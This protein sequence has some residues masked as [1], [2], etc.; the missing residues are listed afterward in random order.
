MV[1]M[2]TASRVYEK[3]NELLGRRGT[4]IV[5]PPFYAMR[6]FPGPPKFFLRLLVVIITQKDW[7]ESLTDAPFDDRQP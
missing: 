3:V 1:I 6:P 7:G 4:E 2:K 5:I